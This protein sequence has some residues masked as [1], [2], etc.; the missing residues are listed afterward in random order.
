M[1]TACGEGVSECRFYLHASISPG[2][3]RKSGTIPLHGGERGGNVR[4]QQISP[5]PW[6]AFADWNY[7]DGRLR[8]IYVRFMIVTGV[9]FLVFCF[10]PPRLDDVRI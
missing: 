10:F 1:D 8:N 2:E 4:R 7:R 3:P 5:V 9:L 6:K